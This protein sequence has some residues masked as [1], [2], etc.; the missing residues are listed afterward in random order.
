MAGI[1]IINDYGFNANLPH[2]HNTIQLKGAYGFTN[3]YTTGGMAFDL[4]AYLPSARTMVDMPNYQGYSFH[5]NDSTKK[6]QVYQQSA[7]TGALTE[8][9]NAT[10]LSALSA[11]PW[12]AW[13]Y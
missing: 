7:A 12:M 10:N 2:G 3:S 11:V 5:Y 1:T 9:P 8:V 13:G 6:I 4:T